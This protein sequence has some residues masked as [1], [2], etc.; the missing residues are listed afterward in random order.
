MESVNIYAMRYRGLRE[1]RPRHKKRNELLNLVHNSNI[2]P[3]RQY[4]TLIRHEKIWC[5][6]IQLVF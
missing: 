5:S 6:L 1:T 3:I 2:T 4:I